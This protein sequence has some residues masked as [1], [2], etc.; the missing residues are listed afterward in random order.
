MTQEKMNEVF[1]GE[2]GQQCNSLFS[3]PDDAIFI[4]YC[5]A[6]QHCTENGLPKDIIEWWEEYS[7]SDPNP[8]I[9]NDMK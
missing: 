5:E 9:R 8:T 6:S 1:A 7:G 3:T 4:R 2:L